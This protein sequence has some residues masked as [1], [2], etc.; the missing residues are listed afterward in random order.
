MT[1]STIIKAVTPTVNPSIEIIVMTDTPR[2]FRL[3]RRW[4]SA[5][6]SGEIHNRW[7]PSDMDL[8]L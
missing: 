8:S 2:A 7:N 5:M 6:R 3:E 4:E 1:A